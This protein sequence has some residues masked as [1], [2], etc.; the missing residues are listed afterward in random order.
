MD[1]QT[2]LEVKAIN[3]RKELTEKNNTTKYSE[4]G[5]QAKKGGE[6]TGSL[7]THNITPD[8]TSGGDENYDIPQRNKQL[9]YKVIGLTQYSSDNQY[10]WENIDTSKNEGQIVLYK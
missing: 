2:N 5:E 3:K 10:K 6:S 9:A 7:F 4:D 1:T 8:I